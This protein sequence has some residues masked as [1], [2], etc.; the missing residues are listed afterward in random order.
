[1]SKTGRER[2]LDKQILFE[3]LVNFIYIIKKEKISSHR[4]TVVPTSSHQVS[5]E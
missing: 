2:I 3:K 1:M 4:E 5:I